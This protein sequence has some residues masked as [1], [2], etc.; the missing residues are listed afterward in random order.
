MYLTW[1]F[2][3]K[4]KLDPR[5]VV[6]GIKL[7][8]PLLHN[9]ETWYQSILHGL[10]YNGNRPQ[11]ISERSVY[12]NKQEF[13][14]HPAFSMMSAKH[15]TLVRMLECWDHYLSWWP[16]WFYSFPALLYSYLL[17]HLITRFQILSGSFFL[18]FTALIVTGPQGSQTFQ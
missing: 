6:I 13:H 11:K 16:T 14:F 2:V 15:L 8:I 1:N 10:L 17:S 7:L 4:T 18:V 12:N 5:A 3:C 9:E